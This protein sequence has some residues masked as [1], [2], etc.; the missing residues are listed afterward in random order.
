VQAGD[1]LNAIAKRFGVSVAAITGSNPQIADPN[2]IF[3]GQ[4]I[5]AARAGRTTVDLGNGYKLTKRGSSLEVTKDIIPELPEL[6]V[7]PAFIAKV[8]I[9]IDKLSSGDQVLDDMA[10]DIIKYFA[11]N[12]PKIANG[13]IKAVDI[14]AAV[15]GIGWKAVTKIVPILGTIDDLTDT[16][17]GRRFGE[18]VAVE[19]GKYYGSIVD[20]VVRILKG[21][22]NPKATELIGTMATLFFIV[23]VPTPL[24]VVR[25]LG[26]DGWSLTKEIGKKVGGVLEDALD[27]LGS[28]FEDVGEF[29]GDLI[30]EIFG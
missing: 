18:E 17:F 24:G 4:I 28:A 6:D 23:A 19:I 29:F 26:A 14:G 7:R 21:E 8:D 9:P 11:E 16:I 20:E 13:K 2:R 10:N 1:T 12:A 3:T 30:D 22:S 15:Y 5:V 25:V 27:A